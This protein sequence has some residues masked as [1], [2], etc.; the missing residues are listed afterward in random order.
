MKKQTLLWIAMMLTT[1]LSF[2]QTTAVDFTLTDCD[3]NSHTLFPIIDSGNVVVLVYEHQCSSCTYGATKL[4]T[5]INENFSS[6]KNIRI[7]YLDNGPNPCSSIKTWISANSLLPG[8][9]IDYSNDYSSPYGAGMPVIVITA[10]KQHK[11]YIIANNSTAQTT[12]TNFKN[13]LQSAITDV[14]NGINSVQ[15]STTS[16]EIY[17]NPA[18]SDKIWVKLNNSG[19]NLLSYFITNATGQIILTSKTTENSLSINEISLAGI[20][21]GVYFFFLNTTEGQIDKKLL[22]RR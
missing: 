2:A 18:V 22:I 20:E 8:P 11:V 6:A 13:A 7:M 1:A 15:I 5:A 9:A 19:N 17:P 4:K 21:N 16:F 14:S 3:G 12:I 10:T